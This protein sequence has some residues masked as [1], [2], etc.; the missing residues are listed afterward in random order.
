[1]KY[2]IIL[3]LLLIIVPLLPALNILFP[4]GTILAERLLF[5][6]SAGYCLLLSEILIGE[7]NCD[8]FSIFFKIKN[9]LFYQFLS[10]ITHLFIQF[11]NLSILQLQQFFFPIFIIL[12]FKVEDKINMKTNVSSTTKSEEVDFMVLN[13]KIK[14]NEKIKKIVRFCEGKKSK[15][16]DYKCPEAS[17]N[18][19]NLT[20]P[21]T[22]KIEKNVILTEEKNI[23]MFQKYF[24][25]YQKLFFP[26]VL[27]LLFSYRVVTRTSDWN[28]EIQL[29]RSALNVCPLS[30]KVN[31]C[32]RAID[33]II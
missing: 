19:E 8:F 1:M 4:I 9:S 22:N 25:S 24:I 15:K 23:F 17:K 33:N 16:N 10:N 12:K 30:V 29:Y 27:F 32:V 11:K 2:N 3:Y 18:S 21:V 7:L 13:N 26:M 6:P 20:V 28:S 14:K 5:I 31:A